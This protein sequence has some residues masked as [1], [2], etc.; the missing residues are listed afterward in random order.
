MSFTTLKRTY[1][2]I[3]VGVIEFG[4]RC[5]GNGEVFLFSFTFIEVLIMLMFLGSSP[6][7]LQANTPIQ[8]SLCSCLCSIIRAIES[9]CIDIKRSE[10]YLKLHWVILVLLQVLPPKSHC[11]QLY[12]YCK[13]WQKIY[14]CSVQFI[15][16]CGSEL[17]T[18]SCTSPS[19]WITCHDFC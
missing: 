13:Y 3:F 8:R 2:L 4:P 12:S 6:S 7:F 17:L 5:L 15:C 14:C 11:W 1:Y 19:T 10:Y 9:V 16:V 18:G